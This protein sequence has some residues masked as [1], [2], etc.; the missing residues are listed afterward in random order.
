MTI[1]SGVTVK[2]S[3]TNQG[4]YSSLIGNGWQNAA[5][6]EAGTNGEPKPS[7]GKT[8]L[9]LRL[10]TVPLPAVRSPLRMMTSVF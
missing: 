8:K 6:A 9:R 4:L 5:D 10:T 3:D 2:F 7:E 1:S